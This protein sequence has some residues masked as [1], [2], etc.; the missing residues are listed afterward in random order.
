MWYKLCSTCG[1][2]RPPRSTH[3]N[4]C[5]NCVE[6]FDH[7]CPWIGNCVGKR[8]YLSFY[9]FLLLLNLMTF[10]LI[11]FSILHIVKHTQDVQRQLINNDKATLIGLSGSIVPL[12]VIIYGLLA[13][14]FITNLFIYHTRLIWRSLTTKEELKHLFMNPFDNMFSRSVGLNWKNALCPVKKKK[15][16][17]NEL[18]WKPLKLKDIEM[19]SLNDKRVNHN[20]I[21]SENIRPDV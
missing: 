6:R 4:D 17:L 5:N 18:K 15:T 9:I 1:T 8:N 12:F 3:C 2:M 20:V 11:A 14:A 10:Y 13:M 7:H 21:V 16:L 19:S